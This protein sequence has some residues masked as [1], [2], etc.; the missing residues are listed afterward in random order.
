MFQRFGPETRP[1]GPLVVPAFGVLG[2]LLIWELAVRLAHLPRWFLPA[3]SAIVQ[4][5][6]RDQ[7][8]L[9]RHT[10]VTLEEVLVGLALSLVLGLALALAIAASPTLERTLYPAIVA[11]Q[12]IPV[13]ALAPLLLIWLGYGLSPKVVV[14]V[15]T[16]FF[17][18]TVNT[19]DG[20]RNV[21]PE[22]VD[23]VRSMGGRGWQVFRIVRLPGALPS[24][25]SGLRVAA[26]VSVIGALIGEWVG[27]SAGLGYLMIRSASQFLT[28]RVF[29]A[30][31]IAA[32]LSIGLFWLIGWVE[33]ITLRWRQLPRSERP[34]AAR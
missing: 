26:A 3:P 14:V 25:F 19:A 34:V 2:G 23:L 11:S 8:L 21:D 9:W 17:P 28:D 7:A 32:V 20:L 5:F 24:F 10:A 18:I 1:Y 27:S 4:A 12:A 22:L 6:A 33:R 16:C 30:V 15:L 29:A 13:I 31:V